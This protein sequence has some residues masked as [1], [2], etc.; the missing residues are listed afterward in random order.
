LP[1]EIQPDA[2]MAGPISRKQADEKYTD[3]TQEYLRRYSHPDIHTYRTQM[4]FLNKIAEFC[5]KER[6]ELVVVNMPITPD[7][8][9]LLK[10][11]GYRGYL[12]GLRE[13][14][15]FN[16]L[17]GVYDLNNFAKYSHKDFHDTV[18][19]NAFGGRKFFDDLTNAVRSDL[20]MREIIQMSGEHMA[21]NKKLASRE[22]APTF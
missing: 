19:L 9:R 14:A 7:N 3:N 2:V 1:A 16:K 15:I 12:Q 18:H 13:F 10:P 22:S 21:K 11:G 20:R 5:R 4:F 17:S 8:L 6:I